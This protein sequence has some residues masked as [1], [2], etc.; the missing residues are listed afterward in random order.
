M[1]RH[2][3]APASRR[4]PSCLNF[5]PSFVSLAFFLSFKLHA[6]RAECKSRSDATK[7]TSPGV[8]APPSRDA[9]AWAWKEK[10][11][12][13]RG[14]HG[15]SSCRRTRSGSHGLTLMHNNCPCEN[16]SENYATDGRNLHLSPA[17]RNSGCSREML[18]KIARAGTRACN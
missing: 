18:P 6:N 10:S 8:R 9:C 14:Q 13:P 3:P 17:R 7:L 11:F 1:L 4:K 5:T 15:L 12:P 16:N 2:P